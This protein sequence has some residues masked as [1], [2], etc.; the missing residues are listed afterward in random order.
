MFTK[1]KGFFRMRWVRSTKKKKNPFCYFE[2]FGVSQSCSVWINIFVRNFFLMLKTL[3][4]DVQSCRIQ[5]NFWGALNFMRTSAGLRVEIDKFGLSYQPICVEF[6]AA[7][8]KFQEK[9]KVCEV[10]SENCILNIYFL[11]FNSK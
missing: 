11:N 7:N 3:I 9:D 10:L 5:L 1:L 8:F 6:T 4:K 2:C